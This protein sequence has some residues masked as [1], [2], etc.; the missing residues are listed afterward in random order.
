MKNTKEEIEII[1]AFRELKAEKAVKEI[2]AIKESLE[3]DNA[4]SISLRALK[5]VAQGVFDFTF[6]EPALVRS[7]KIT[8][9]ER[10][11]EFDL[12]LFI[13]KP[14]ETV[15]LLPQKINYLKIIQ[16]D[17]VFFENNSCK[18]EKISLTIGSYCLITDGQKKLFINIKK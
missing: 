18:K 2:K 6:R 1:Q 15:D 9:D 11:I 12:G 5:Y 4:I 7:E 16:G 8:E 13:L 3:K 10:V 14:N 17:K